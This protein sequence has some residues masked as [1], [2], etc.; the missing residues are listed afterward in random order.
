MLKSKLSKKEYKEIALK[1]KDIIMLIFLYGDEFVKD[2]DIWHKTIVF[3]LAN[4]LIDIK[5]F[6]SHFKFRGKKTKSTMSPELLKKCVKLVM[7][8]DKNN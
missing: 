7:D 4:D 5:K 8:Y 1:Y 3:L 2:N 6:Y